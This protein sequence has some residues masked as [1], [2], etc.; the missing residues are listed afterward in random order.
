MTTRKDKDGA[1]VKVQLDEEGKPIRV[2]DK[3]AP[4]LDVV[5]LMHDILLNGGTHET[6]MR[7][8]GEPQA[9]ETALDE[10]ERFVNEMQ[11]ESPAEKLLAARCCSSTL[12][13]SNSCGGSASG[14]CR[15]T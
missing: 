12:T 1:T 5:E 13:S 8:L 6:L 3:G 9:A 14:G 10:I 7:R 11:P 2:R 15:P 4:S